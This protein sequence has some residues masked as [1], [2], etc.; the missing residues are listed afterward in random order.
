MGGEKRT[1]INVCSPIERVR[2]FREVVKGYS[3][4]EAI[5]EA[6][7]CLKCK[8]PACVPS[9]PVG[10]RIP[11]YIAAIAEVNFDKAL[12]II[13][14]NNPLPGVCGRVC[15]KKCE[16]TCVRGKKGEPIA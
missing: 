9:C 8:K 12:G 7:R 13:M 5:E 15:T 2:D 3:R 1:P 6:K 4:E 10:Q 11:E 14:E 16:T